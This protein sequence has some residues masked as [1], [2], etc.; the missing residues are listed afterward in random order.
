MM[1]YRPT[2]VLLTTNAHRRGHS[3]SNQVMDSK[4]YKYKSIIVLL[5]SRKKVGI[6][7]KVDLSRMM[8]LNDNKIDYI[9]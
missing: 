3:S 5:M 1:T 4:G 7:K 9:H 8:T 6:N 2:E